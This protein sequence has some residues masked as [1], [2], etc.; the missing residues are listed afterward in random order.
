VKTCSDL[1]MGWSSVAHACRQPAMRHWIGFL[2]G[3][4]PERF[5][6]YHE[7]FD[8]RNCRLGVIGYLDVTH[9]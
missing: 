2:V 7:V 4:V 6:A 1:E 5:A 9:V 8:W 3:A